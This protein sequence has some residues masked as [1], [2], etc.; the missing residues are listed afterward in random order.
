MNKDQLVRSISKK[1]GISLAQAQ[2]IIDQI[3][4]D[5]RES[6]LRGKPVRLAGFGA[7]STRLARNKG[8]RPDGTKWTAEPRKKVVFTA[9]LASGG[10]YARKV[11]IVRSIET[12]QPVAP[13]APVS[14]VA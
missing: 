6:A 14:S 9:Y 8:Q 2:R 3:F 12:G 10:A 5:I 1:Q 11:Q 4:G 13:V 7:F